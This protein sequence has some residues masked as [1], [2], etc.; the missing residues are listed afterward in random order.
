VHG[1][2][3]P[4]HA[5]VTY[6]SELDPPARIWSLF[7]LQAADR[8][9]TWSAEPSRLLDVAAMTRHAVYDAATRAGLAPEI[10]TNLMGHGDE[11]RILIHPLP[12]VGH[13]YADGRIR[14]VL[15]AA[16]VTLDPR[17]WRAVIHRLTG[18]DLTPVGAAEPVAI[19]LPASRDDKL[20]GRFTTD[21]TTWTTAT[22]VVLPGHDHRRGKARPERALSRLLRYAGIPQALV[23]SVTFEPGPR[24]RGSPRAVD[25]RLPR[26]LAGRPLVHLSVRWKLPV[27]GPLA[28][29]AGVGYGFGVFSAC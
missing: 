17:T 26:H 23:E 20:I 24:L 6:R 29:G 2:P 16:P 13:R 3:E 19:L 27:A 7:S 15:L 8:D 22:P 9:R 4:D 18:A 12:N 28:L 11:E 1:V 10:I 25:C 14:R 5:Q 21:S